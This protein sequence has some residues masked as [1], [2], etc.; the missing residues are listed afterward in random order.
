M[1]YSKFSESKLDNLSAKKEKLEAAKQ[2]YLKKNNYS[3]RK[4]SIREV[5]ERFQIPR[6]TFRRHLANPEVRH[7][8]SSLLNDE[9]K[10]VFLFSFFSLTLL[11][12]R[13]LRKKSRSG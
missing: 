13:C 4:W 3:Y 6:E 11:E 9:E 10:E 8:R 2:F 12:F 7:G 5:A 1:S